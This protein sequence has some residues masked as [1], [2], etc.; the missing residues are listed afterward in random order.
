MTNFGKSTK[1]KYLSEL[2]FTN[3]NIFFKRHNITALKC[4]NKALKKH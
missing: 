3:H 1:N 2:I 4:I